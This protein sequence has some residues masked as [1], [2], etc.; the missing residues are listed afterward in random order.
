MVLY[1]MIKKKFGLFEINDSKYLADGAL[2]VQLINDTIYDIHDTEEEAIK[3]I[4]GFIPNGKYIVM[5][6]Y[7]KE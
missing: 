1:G 3:A 7:I 5:P 6:I 4:D 2:K